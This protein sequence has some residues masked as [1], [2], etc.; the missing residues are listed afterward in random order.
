MLVR[1]A[2]Y[3]AIR[4]FCKAALLSGALSAAGL[5]AAGTR[6][7]APSANA[8]LLTLRARIAELTAQ[9]AQGLKQRDELS[10]AVRDAE[11]AISTQRESL[12]LV[13]R[14]QVEIDKRRA[15][16]GAARAKVQAQLEL[17]RADLARAARAAYL[18][19]REPQWRLLLN[20]RNPAAVGR[21]LAYH[22][23]V[24]RAQE[25]QIHAIEEDLARLQTL[26]QQIEE[27]GAR[28]RELGEQ[29]T[30]QLESLQSARIQRTAALS[31]QQRR[32]DS[33]GQQIE[34]LKRDEQA[35]ESLLADLNKVAPDFSLGAKLPFARM[36]GRL[37]WPVQGRIAA[38][39]R[40]A[41]G[42]SGAS[43][44]RWNGLL[45]ET[46]RG[47]KVRAPYH[48]R[49]IYSD[50]LQGMGMLLIIEHGNGY[51][52]LFG[53]TEILFKRVGDV[54]TP[55]EVI[56]GL[57]EINTP[58]LYFEIRRGRTALDPQKWLKPQR[59]QR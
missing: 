21:A 11:L 44:M 18:L 5:A 51:L 14:E 3:S 52:S 56:A 15:L 1:A 22:S 48:G 39:F 47:A 16:L 9:V 29:A 7:A 13:Q 54:V 8:Q 38:R 6:A 37:P 49:V 35:L 55:G 50:W 26:D 42:G 25:A 24:G 27:Q 45:I 46:E 53:R 2:M 59:R 30:R 43:E 32:V 20:Q 23:Y 58:Q 4:S 36:Q 19:G 41:R 12:A 17:Q 10:A 57:S 33:A 40:A 28:L 31:A 34:K